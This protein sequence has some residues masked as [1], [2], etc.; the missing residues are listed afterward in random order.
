M[1]DVHTPVS[2][3][4]CINSNRKIIEKQS[5][6]AISKMNSSHSCSWRALSTKSLF[7]KM[8]KMQALCH[9]NVARIILLQIDLKINAFQEIP[10][11][12]PVVKN[13]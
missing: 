5:C 2:I 7:F 11:C 9:A 1:T 4:C 3:A 8:K 12:Q 13:D 10:K 6:E